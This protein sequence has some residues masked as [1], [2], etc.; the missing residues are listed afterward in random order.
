MAVQISVDDPA[1][2]ER[3]SIR[4]AYQAYFTDGHYELRYPAANR[5]TLLRILGLL[6][7]RG[8]A[9]L[10][11]DHGCGSGRYLIPLLKAS[12]ARFV[13]CD[14]STEALSR[15][16]AS[17]DESGEGDRVRMVEAG[18][19][20]AV[21]TEVGAAGP[22]DLALLIFGVLAHVSKRQARLEL[23]RSLRGLLEP[24]SGRLLLSVPNR[25]RRFPFRRGRE[26]DGAGGANGVQGLPASSGEDIR[27]TRRL[28]GRYIRLHYHLYD[29][30][31][32]RAE[33]R[34]AGFRILRV[35]AE[36][37]LPE[38]WITRSRLL[39][40]LDALAATRMPARWG[41]GLLAVAVPEEAGAP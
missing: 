15:L 41:Y 18:A 26:T 35:E 25:R 23:L 12:D 11:L 22:F 39:G 6:R 13:A 21:P 33:L 7:A 16:R 29:I 40:R 10:V 24:G 1:L 20:D 19:R 31:D 37:V 2:S 27:Y 5:L 9:P 34:E 36:S 32:L 8:P 17:V 30:E 28:G 3:V 38:S 4:E 14:I